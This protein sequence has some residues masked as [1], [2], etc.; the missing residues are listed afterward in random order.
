MSSEP[1]IR[2]NPEQ[3]G[4]SRTLSSSAIESSVRLRNTENND[5]AMSDSILYAIK[6]TFTNYELPLVRE[7]IQDYL[8]DKEGQ[9]PLPL[10]DISAISTAAEYG[11]PCEIDSDRI[12]TFISDLVSVGVFKK[13]G[14]QVAANED[15]VG[16]SDILMASLKSISG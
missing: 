14:E 2:A 6:S 10:T 16:L 1:L 15:A 12:G 7:F 11:C 8:N 13:Q 4:L 3:S 9:K 5:I